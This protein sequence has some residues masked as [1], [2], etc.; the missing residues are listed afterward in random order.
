M[1]RREFSLL[2][3]FKKGGEVL[4]AVLEEYVHYWKIYGMFVLIPLMIYSDY[5]K[6]MGS[7]IGWILMT[8]AIY[9]ILFKFIP[10][11]ITV[12]FKFLLNIYVTFLGEMIDKREESIQM[13]ERVNESKQKK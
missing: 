12:F 3:S 10:F 9:G 7:P 5:K 8:G 1:R 2:V 13:M 11:L 4:Y 6:G